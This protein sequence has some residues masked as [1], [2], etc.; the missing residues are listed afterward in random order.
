MNTD[1]NQQ[2]PAITT[3]SGVASDDKSKGADLSDWQ[4]SGGANEVTASEPKPVTTSH[5]PAERGGSALDDRAKEFEVFDD[6]QA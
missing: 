5:S 3:K 4:G 6:P 2:S 1:N